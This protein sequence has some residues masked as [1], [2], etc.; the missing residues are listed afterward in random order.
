M[1]PFQVAQKLI[2]PLDTVGQ[3]VSKAR[4][5]ETTLNRCE[6]NMSDE[7]PKRP[8]GRP[9][10]FTGEVGRI[11]HSLR[12]QPSVDSRVRSAAATSCRSIAEELEVRVKSTVDGIVL[13]PE[14][15]ELRKALQVSAEQN[16]RPV[17]AEAEARL[18]ESFEQDRVFGRPETYALLAMLA[19]DIERIER[20]LGMSWLDAGEAPDNH[21]AEDLIA[22]FSERLQW[23]LSLNDRMRARA[24]SRREQP[25]ERASATA[26]HRS[27]ARLVGQEEATRLMAVV[28]PSSTFDPT[29]F[30]RA[31]FDETMRP[32]DDGDA[33]QAA[34]A[35]PHVP[36]RG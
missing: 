17:N 11:A 27:D 18:V 4:S 34:P 5:L 33:D 1:F 3:L 23:E 32:D 21:V 26:S 24:R 12:L 15:L 8:G 25:E 22:A 10:K 31:T 9:P 30:G 36:A 13:F 6:A 7:K 2:S 14:T 19:K 29:L 20:D 35:E 28:Q 16:G